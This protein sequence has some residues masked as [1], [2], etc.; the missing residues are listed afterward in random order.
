MTNQ[1]TKAEHITN[2]YLLRLTDQHHRTKDQPGHWMT[3]RQ[4]PKDKHNLMVLKSGVDMKQVTI[5]KQKYL[6]GKS[7]E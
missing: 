1:I 5:P 2:V 6:E 7:L 4:E 3:C